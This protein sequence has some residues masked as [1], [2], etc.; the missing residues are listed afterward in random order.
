MHHSVE[1]QW[2][3]DKNGRMAG[4]KTITSWA[5][6]FQLCVPGRNLAFIGRASMP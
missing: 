3:A 1:M 4:K 6:L 2:D 5:E